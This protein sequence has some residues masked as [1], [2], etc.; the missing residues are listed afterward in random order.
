[1]IS[2][3]GLT[4][5]AIQK[6]ANQLTRELNSMEE[7]SEVMQL[8]SQRR[9]KVKAVASLPPPIILPESAGVQT[10]LQSFFAAG[11]E[12]LS[13]KPEKEVIVLSDEDS[14]VEMLDPVAPP[15]TKRKD[16][17]QLPGESKSPEKKIRTA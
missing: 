17:G 5:A 15:I 4:K 6:R 13:F 12:H 11:R 9:N 1:M 10:G 8:V 14:D 3:S 2:E 7:T 16:E